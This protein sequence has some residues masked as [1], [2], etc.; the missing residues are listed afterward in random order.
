L[1]A[2]DTFIAQQTPV[3]AA[4]LS[5]LIGYM[6]MHHPELPE[7]L[8]YGMP[9]YRP[10]KHDFIAFSVHTAHFTVHSLD[11]SYLAGIRSA[12]PKNHFNKASFLVKYGEKAMREPL[13]RILDDLVLRMKETPAR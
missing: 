10:N 9:A 6:R 4:W 3:A 8:Y 5:D 2:V 12:F 7:S 13:Y 1:N 11:F